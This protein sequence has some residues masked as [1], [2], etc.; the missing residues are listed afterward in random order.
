MLIILKYLTCQEMYHLE[1]YD[2]M[3]EGGGGN[4]IK[5]SFEIRFMNT[6]MP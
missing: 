3:A 2:S 4:I 1:K 6:N 5:L